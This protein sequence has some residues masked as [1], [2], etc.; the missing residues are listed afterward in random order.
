[1]AEGWGCEP[2]PSAT[3]GAN[4]Q[5]LASFVDDSFV[6]VGGFGSVSSFMSVSIFSF[7]PLFP[8]YRVRLVWAADKRFIPS[9]V[10]TANQRRA[11]VVIGGLVD[12]GQSNPRDQ[13]RFDKGCR[14][15]AHHLL[16]LRLAKFKK[17]A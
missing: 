8:R 9:P 2:S 17:P 15:L 16:T 14:R 4:V 13:C 7:S 5:S 10:R 1:M 11:A 12:D 6:C 3:L